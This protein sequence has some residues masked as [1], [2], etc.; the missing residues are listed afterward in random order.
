M[1]IFLKPYFLS[2]THCL[3]PPTP[4]PGSGLEVLEWDGK[5]IEFFTN[6]TFKCKHRRR[7]EDD[8]DRNY[9]NATCLPE[10]Q[11]NVSEWHKCVKSKP[12]FVHL[13]FYNPSQNISVNVANFCPALPEL[14]VERWN[15]SAKLQLPGETLLKCLKKTRAPSCQR[16]FIEKTEHDETSQEHHFVFIL[17]TQT[18]ALRHFAVNISFSQDVDTTN[19]IV[20]T[21]IIASH[22]N[23]FISRFLF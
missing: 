11:W 12:F 20:S 3:K 16:F 5:P 19:I 17:K 4:P 6:I 7:F 18:E 1:D 14:N 9:L 13:L 15:H 10:N 21:H 8:F 2:G 23:S 22:V